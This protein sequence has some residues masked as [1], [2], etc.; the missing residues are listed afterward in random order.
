M[1]STCLFCHTSLGSNES[2]GH[3]PVGSRLAF[4]AA[5]GRLW[6][7]CPKCERWNLSPIE[8]RWEAIEEAERAYRDTRKH[9]AT[10][11]IGLARLADGTDLIRI[12]EP[13]RPEFVSWRY[14]QV[15]GK[16]QTF[17]YRNV[18]MAGVVGSVASR[19]GEHALGLAMA[20]TFTLQL[21]VQLGAGLLQTRKIRVSVTAD[22][23]RSYR[24]T[25]GEAHTAR[26]EVDRDSHLPQLVVSTSSDAR[27]G[28]LMDRLHWGLRSQSAFAFHEQHTIRLTGAR[29][30]RALSNLMPSVNFAGGS[31]ADVAKATTLLEQSAGPDALFARIST[32]RHR[33]P[34]QLGR[35]AN[36][37]AATTPDVR[38]ALEMSLHEEDERR[39]LDGELREL[40]QRWR[41]AEEI[42]A[43]S[44]NLFVGSAS[45]SQTKSAEPGGSA[46]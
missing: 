6:V 41:D 30:M 21:G 40:E 19:F 45:S 15:F 18:L 39:A 25:H 17:F 2:I 14:G 44:D 36:M 42:A 5:K 28:A 26:F 32:G 23:G 34:W 33:A 13:E 11:N 16:R 12:G 8:E 3:F 7:V 4:D 35:H 22:S 10:E 31:N 38:L 24:L 46:L 37:I 1:Y 9:A 27:S 29:A 20:G 43:I